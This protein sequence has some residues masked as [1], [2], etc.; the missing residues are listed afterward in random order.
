MVPNLAVT[1]VEMTTFFAV[2]PVAAL[3]VPAPLAIS[4]SP[5]AAKHRVAIRVV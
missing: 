1:K 2:G 3:D 5:P 4:A